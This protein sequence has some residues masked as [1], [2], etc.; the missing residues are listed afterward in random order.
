MS[1]LPTTNGVTLANKIVFKVP[2]VLVWPKLNTP[3]VFKPKK[4]DPKIRY[5]TDLKLAPDVLKNVQKTLADLAK[6][7]LPDVAE[8][9]LP[10]KKDKKTGDILLSATSGEKYRPPLFDAKNNSVPPTV[11]V[12]G[13]TKAVVEV[14][15]NFYEMSATN[16]GINLYIRAVQIIELQEGGFKSSFEEAEGFTYKGAEGDKEDSSDDHNSDDADEDGESTY[17]F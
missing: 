7:Y 11:I 5:T 15:V 10:F 6:K 12:G 17:K 3:D 2:G 9:K 8:P 4:G 13:G 1:S 14:T 16:S